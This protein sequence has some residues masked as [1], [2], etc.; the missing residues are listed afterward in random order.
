MTIIVSIYK[1]AVKTDCN[2]YRGTSLST[3]YTILFNILLSKLSSYVDEI[4]GDHQC[5]VRHNRATTDQIFAFVRRWKKW[6]YNETV[7]QLFIDFEKAYHSARR[8]VSYNFLIE[9]WGHP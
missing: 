4:T 3:S 6:E 1:K 7:H 9:L 8:E 5:G 2:N